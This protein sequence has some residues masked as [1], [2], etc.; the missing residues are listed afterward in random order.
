MACWISQQRLQGQDQQ[1]DYQ[2]HE[3][4]QCRK[5]QNG[6]V[7]MPDGEADWASLGWKMGPPPELTS[8]SPH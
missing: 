3:K 1:T 7:G 8:G 4:Q 2:D 6:G 5:E